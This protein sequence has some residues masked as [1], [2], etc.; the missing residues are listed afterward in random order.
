M[1][2]SEATQMQYKHWNISLL[3]TNDGMESLFTHDALQKMPK[4]RDVSI[5]V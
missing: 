1:N 2:S 4:G 3:M 5:Q